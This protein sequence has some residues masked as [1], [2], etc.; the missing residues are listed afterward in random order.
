MKMFRYRK[1]QKKSTLGFRKGV[2]TGPCQTL[3]MEGK[4]PYNDKDIILV[5]FKGR[6]VPAEIVNVNT[7]SVTVNM[8]GLDKKKVIRY[9]NIVKKLHT[10]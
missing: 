5:K 3:F 7:S 8:A 6:V 9:D 1:P 4:N 10:V 2:K